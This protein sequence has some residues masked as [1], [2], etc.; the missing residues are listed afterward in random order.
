[1]KSWKEVRDYITENYEISDYDEDDDNI[2]AM[3]FL[4]NGRTQTAVVT[5]REKMIVFGSVIGNINKNDIKD[6]LCDLT[7]CRYGRI[8]C[9]DDG[10][11]FVSHIEESFR[12]KYRC[13]FENCSSL[14]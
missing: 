13:H 9:T 7:E 3:V 11:C 6:A 1:M 4:K 5:R 12:G 8:T 2:T 14:C 10:E